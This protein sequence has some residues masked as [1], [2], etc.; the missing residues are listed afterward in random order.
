[1]SAYR[2]WIGLIVFLIIC[3]AVA[4]A[5][6]VFTAPSVPHWYAGLKKPSWTPPG[7]VFAPV[8]SFLY[9]TMAVAAWLV[10]RR[11]GFDLLGGLIPLALFALQLA[12][13]FT[14]SLIFFGLHMPG[15]AFVDI[16]LLWLAILATIIAFWRITPAAGVLLLPYIAWVTYAATLNYGI[17]RMNL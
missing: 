11:A 9:L 10:W 4:W 13:N 16:V 7:S 3:F 8:W 5:G 2:Q 6:S 17:W 1:V 12:F 14:W 15:L